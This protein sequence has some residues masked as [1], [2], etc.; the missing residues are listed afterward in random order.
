MFFS[1]RFFLSIT[2]EISLLIA[3]AVLVGNNLKFFML[4]T[5]LAM[6]VTSFVLA[7]SHK[8]NDS[9][10]MEK[11]I[12]VVE[13]VKVSYT[14]EQAARGKKYYEKYCAECHGKEFK[15]GVN[16]GPVLKGVSFLEKYANGA[17]ASWLFEFMYYMMPPDQAGRFSV[18]KYTDMMA[19]ILKKNGFKSSGEPLPSD[20]ESLENLILEK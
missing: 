4:S 8:K 20:I 11:K 14:K 13:V 9:V 12:E 19:Y 7:D 15:G 10:E 2:K 16:G 1:L 3:T 5:T 6:L 17:P 18:K